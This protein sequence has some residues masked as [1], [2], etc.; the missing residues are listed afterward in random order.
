M[1]NDYVWRLYLK[2][3]GNKVVQLFEDNLTK[4]FT[5]EYIEKVLEFHQVYCSDEQTKQLIRD[6]LE[7]YKSILQDAV[8]AIGPVRYSTKGMNPYTH[9][10]E[11][12]CEDYLLVDEDASEFSD[13][14]IFEVF[15]GILFSTEISI[16]F[17]SLF[18]PLYFPFNFNVIRQIAET[19]GIQLPE[20]PLEKDYRGR[21]L[22]YGQI[23]EAFSQFRKEHDLT[24]Y[25]FLAFLYDFAPKYIGGIDSYFVSSTNETKSAYFIGAPWE[26]DTNYGKLKGDRIICE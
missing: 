22:Y 2:S 16:F 17:P 4:N 18:V 25:E 19:F 10:L 23:C 15:T 11:W 9:C 1:F 12:Y 5:D 8:E 24:P 3:G 7:E 26:S 14:C 6:E 20:V 21:F 13:K